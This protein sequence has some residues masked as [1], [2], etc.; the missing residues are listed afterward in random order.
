[1]ILIQIFVAEDESLI[2]TNIIRKEEIGNQSSS[3]SA[4]EPSIHILSTQNKDETDT[5]GQDERNSAPATQQTSNQL[6]SPATQRTSNE[7]PSS[8]NERTTNQSLAA[9]TQRS[10]N[11]SPAAATQRTADQSPAAVITRCTSNQSSKPTPPPTV[12]LPKNTE[13]Q[14]QSLIIKGKTKTFQN[15]SI[16]HP[17]RATQ[18]RKRAVSRKTKTK[19]KRNKLIPILLILL[20]MLIELFYKKVIDRI[21][22]ILC[23]LNRYM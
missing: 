19:Q 21:I 10:F 23:S 12:N 4:P 7:A 17:T 5:L 1:M 14:K 15:R 3:A 20:Q 2:S 13:K 8:A 22:D 9:A 16:L 18:T 11:Q 6:P